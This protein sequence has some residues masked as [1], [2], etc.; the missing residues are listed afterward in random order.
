MEMMSQRLGHPVQLERMFGLLFLRDSDKSNFSP[1]NL[2]PT[3]IKISTAHNY[4]NVT[5][6]PNNNLFFF[7]PDSNEVFFQNINFMCP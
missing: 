1:S 6:Q 7:S 5:F 4:E 2:F 3:K